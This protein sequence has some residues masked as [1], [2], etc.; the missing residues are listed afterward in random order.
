MEHVMGGCGLTSCSC[1]A[2]SLS[3]SASASSA[4]ILSSCPPHTQPTRHTISSAFIRGQAP[5]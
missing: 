1:L 3:A 5:F 2:L 4:P